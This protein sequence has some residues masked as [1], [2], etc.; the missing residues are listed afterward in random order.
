MDTITTIKLT[1]YTK[2]RLDHLRIHR[3]ET[4]EEIIE[5]M[6]EILNIC[7]INPLKAHHKLTSLDNQ[8]KANTKKSSPSKRKE[9]PRKQVKKPTPKPRYTKR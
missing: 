2:K 6:L 1:K 7:K 4:Y 9:E 3:R 5:K 8:I